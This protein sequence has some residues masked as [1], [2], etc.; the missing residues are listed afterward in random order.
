MSKFSQAVRNCHECQFSNQRTVSFVHPF[1]TGISDSLDFSDVYF[2]CSSRRYINGPYFAL[3]IMN[4][5]LR[6]TL[7]EQ[8][9][10]KGSRCTSRVNFKG[11]ILSLEAL[12]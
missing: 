3:S 2:E 5:I 7:T 8:L 12:V 6:C 10:Q 1:L 9:L 4:H 11:K